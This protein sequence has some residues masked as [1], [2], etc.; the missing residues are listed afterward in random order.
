[1][2]VEPFSASAEEDRPF[3]AFADGEV[4]GSGGAGCQRDD[5]DPLVEGVAY[6]CGQV[7]D[8]GALVADG[9]AGQIEGFPG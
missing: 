7:S 9:S 1:M 6:V 4:D 3:N 5:D 8:H 2:A